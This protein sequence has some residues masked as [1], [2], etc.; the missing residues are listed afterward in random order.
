[1]QLYEKIMNPHII[2]PVNPH[3]TRE[4][5][6]I[7]PART[8]SAARIAASAFAASGPVMMAGRVALPEWSSLSQPR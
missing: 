6:P 2:Q 5:M 4:I 8:A 7:Y 3:F 1:V